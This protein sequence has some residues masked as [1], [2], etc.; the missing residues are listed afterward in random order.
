MHGELA[1]R[2]CFTHIYAVAKVRS[3]SGHRQLRLR[4]SLSRGRNLPA[5]ERAWD[6]PDTF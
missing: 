6:P 1:H 4:S 3:T 2:E 5:G